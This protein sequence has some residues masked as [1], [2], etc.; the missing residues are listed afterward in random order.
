MH[1]RS[2]KAAWT[3]AAG[4]IGDQKVLAMTRAETFGADGGGDDGQAGGPGF[5]DFEAGPA[6]GEQGNDR[7]AGAGQLRNG[8]GRPGQ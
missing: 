4:V 1:A 2:R 5:E 8:V 7:D 6:A 3:K